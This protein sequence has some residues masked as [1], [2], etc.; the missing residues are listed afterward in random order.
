MTLSISSHLLRQRSLSFVYQQG[1]I[2]KK[3]IK[4][5]QIN[6]INYIFE[7]YHSKYFQVLYLRELITHYTLSRDLVFIQRIVKQ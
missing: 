2:A 1:L 6:K 3:K 7:N 5:I 4:P